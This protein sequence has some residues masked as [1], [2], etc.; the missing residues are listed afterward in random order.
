M[1]YFQP[2]GY[3][4]GATTNLNGAYTAMSAGSCAIYKYGANT[5]NA[6]TAGDG[7]CI[8]FKINSAYGVQM[9]L[10]N[11]GLYMRYVNYATFG[12]WKLVNS[13]N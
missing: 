11:V 10:C 8:Q 13:Y 2:V 7:M 1:N 6:P 5:A 3:S 12:D 9:V 4:P